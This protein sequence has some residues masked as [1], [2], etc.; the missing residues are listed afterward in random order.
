MSE[1][2]SETPTGD[3]AEKWLKDRS[4]PGPEQKSGKE[5]DWIKEEAKKLFHLGKECEDLVSRLPLDSDQLF[6]SEDETVRVM[7]DGIAV[8][9][10]DNTERINLGGK[11]IENIL[12]SSDKFDQPTGERERLL[13]GTSEPFGMLSLSYTNERYLA[14]EEIDYETD[15][16]DYL[17]TQNGHF[18]K[19][20]WNGNESERMKY[21]REISR[22]EMELVFAAAGMVKNRLENTTQA[23]PSK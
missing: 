5:D 2:N 21:T 19:V 14:G 12:L 15:Y 7:H 17:F 10:S 20:S 16:F 9:L 23:K 4:N 18:V 6:R 13:L 22:G 11:E 3:A 1:D 8:D